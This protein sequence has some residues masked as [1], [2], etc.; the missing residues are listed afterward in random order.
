MAKNKRRRSKPKKQHQEDEY[1][2]DEENQPLAKGTAIIDD[3][4]LRLL[5]YLNIRIKRNLFK[6]YG[7]QCAQCEWVTSKSGINGRNA[8]RAHSKKHKNEQRARNHMRIQFRFGVGLL[9]AI[10]LMSAWSFAQPVIH[11]I[12]TGWLTTSTLTGLA[13]LGTSLISAYFLVDFQSLYSHEPTKQRSDGYLA[14]LTLGALVL[15]VEALFASGATP[16]GVPAAWLLSGVLPVAA[17]A[18]TRSELGQAKLRNS[19]RERHSPKYIRRYIAR[20]ADGDAEHDDLHV[21][22]QGMIR[23]KSFV[24]NY[25]KVWQRKALQTLG[26]RVPK[27]KKK[28]NK[29]SRIR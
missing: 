28:T 8:A 4:V 26:L 22:I 13:L 2:D 16:L 9:L 21:N 25:S 17:L 15:I 24:P 18:Y 20:T 1:F 3:Y 14:A 5:R 10:L 6:D 12:P 7:Y 19:R 23:L 11:D 27:R 29:Q